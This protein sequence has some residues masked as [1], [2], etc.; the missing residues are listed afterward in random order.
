M[1]CGK[2]MPPAA[3]QQNNKQEAAN[4]QNKKPW[5]DRKYKSAAC[6]STER[7]VGNQQDAGYD[8]YYDDIKPIDYGQIREYTDPNLIKRAIII[9]TCAL[10]IVVASGVLI[11]LL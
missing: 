2:R 11:Y 1:E 8:R 10:F 5:R 7:T 4:R 9:T 6:T 3:K